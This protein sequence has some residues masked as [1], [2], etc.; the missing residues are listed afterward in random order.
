MPGMALMN[1][2]HR[3]ETSTAR[4]GLEGHSGVEG[5][6]LSRSQ[7]TLYILGSVVLRY[8]WAQAGRAMG[9]G[10]WAHGHQGDDPPTRMGV[11]QFDPGSVRTVRW[12]G[13][14]RRIFLG[15]ENLYAVASLLNILDFLRS[16]KYR[17]L[18]ERGL[19]ARLVYA[20]TS[21]TRTANYEYLNRQ[22][23]WSE[24]SEVLLFLLPLLNATAVKRALRAVLPRTLRSTATTRFDPG[25]GTLFGGGTWKNATKSAAGESSIQCGICGV[26]DVLTP[27]TSEPCGHVFCYFCLRS[28]VLADPD[29]QCPYC[30]AKV[31][32]MRPLASAVSL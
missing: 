32:A 22:L 3:D 7:R 10:D 13:H 29:Y 17:S 6:G 30:L 23:V 8:A 5:P 16:G 18:L 21:A 26:S 9:A 2:R 4:S 24:L 1:L 14:V 19:G 20:R 12:R 28:H 31:E 11:S 27:Y 15:A 25:T